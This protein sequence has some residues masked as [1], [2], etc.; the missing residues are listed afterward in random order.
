MK[1]AILSIGDELLFGEVVDT[2][3]AR[4]AARLADEGIATA[5]KL[6]VG[7]DEAGIASALE[8]LA[9]GHDVVIATGGLGP[10]DDDVTARAVA[11][12]TGRRLV[13]NEEA[14]ARLKEFFDRLGQEMHPANGRQCL[15]PAKA[16]LIPNPAGTASGFHLLLDGCLLIFL[17]GV[18]SEMAVMLEESVVSLVLARR[19]GRQRTRTSTLTVFGLSEAEI[20]ARLSDL[21]RSRP[22]FAVAYCV[23]FPMVQVKLRATGEDETALTAL[24]E[25]GAAMVRE[26]LGDHVVAG[27][28]ETIDTVVAGLFRETG[29]TLALAESCTGGL[30][31]GRITAVAG[32]SGYFLLGAVTYSNDAKSNLLGV[33]VDI[34]AEQGAVSADVAKAM[35]RGARKL[36]GS[37]LALAVTGIA[38]PEGGSPDKPVGT[39]FMALADRAGCSANVYH[40]SGGRE[41]IRTITEITA[42]D[43]LRRRLLAYP[44]DR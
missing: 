40:F 29:M 3:S 33:P 17:P 39:V 27:D 25:D 37:D 38:G 20:G 22:G 9:R 28:G 15:L 44:I 26:R 5:R 21:D 35:A 43:W 14:M 12:A 32:S 6:T 16:E 30:I 7:D 19:S 41:K 1:T 36:A 10:T 23:E 31:A 24:L 13:L 2:N 18:P 42:M 11:R 4:I 8:E 34:L